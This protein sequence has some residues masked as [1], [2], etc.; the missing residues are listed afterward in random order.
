MKVYR[1]ARTQY[2]NDMTGEGA[3]LFGGRWNH[4]SVPCIY[5]SESKA[6]ALLEYTVNVNIEEIPR[7]LSIVTLEIPDA[8][9]RVILQDDL[10]GNW[11][12]S[13]APVST[14]DYGSK[15]LNS[16]SDAVFKIPSTIIADEYNLVLNPL[17]KESKHFRIIDIRDFVYDVR[18]KNT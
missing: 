4:K 3:R 17:H 2:A 5:C 6:L 8:H 14:K 12:E 10:P 11:K 9:I 1:I 13:P 15:L 18:I 7:A 16:L